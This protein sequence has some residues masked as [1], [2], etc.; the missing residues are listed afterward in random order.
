MKRLALLFVTLFILSVSAVGITAQPPAPQSTSATEV[1]LGTAFTYQGRLTD[2]GAPANGSYDLVFKLYDDSAGGSQVG[3]SV[4]QT[5][6]VTD[7]LFTVQLDFGS[8]VFDGNARWLEI[9]VRPAGSTIAYLPLTPRQELTPAPYALHSAST[10]ALQGHAVGADA[11]AEGQVLTWNGGKWVPWPLPIFFWSLTGNSG[12]NPTTNFL[13][14]TDNQPLVIKTNGAEAIRIDTSGNVGIGTTNPTASLHV[15]PSTAVGQA[16]ADAIVAHQSHGSGSGTSTIRGVYGKAE[17]NSWSGTNNLY[18]VYGDGDATSTGGNPTNN[19]Y[20]VYGKATG[21]I[22]G[23]Q[24]AIGGYFTASGA[25]N[26]YAAIFDQGNVGI[27]TTNPAAR[28]EV[29]GTI[30]STSGGF[31]FPDGTVQTTAAIGGGGWS[32]T[33]NAGTNPAT[34]FLGTTDNQAL[35]LRVN[36]ARAL[37]LEPDAASPNLVGGYNGNNAT[38]GVVGAAIGGG[39]ASGQVNRVTDNYGTVGGGGN[40]QAG[41]ANADPTDATYA[42]VGGGESNTASG[43]HAT[44]GGGSLNIAS[45]GHATIAG[46]REN[47]ASSY[48]ATVGGGWGNVVTATYATIGGGI[49]NTVNWEMATIGGGNGNTASGRSATVAGGESNAASG[50]NATVGGGN[51]N[52]ASGDYA[53]V[54]GG[55]LNTA[56]GSH[57][58]AAGQQAKAN[59]PGCFVWSDTTGIDLPCDNNDRWVARASGGVYFYTSPTSHLISNGVYVAPGGNSWNS[60]SDRATKENFVLVDGRAILEALA[61]LPVHEYNLKSQDPTIRHLGPV[62]QDFYAAFGYGESDRAINM[63]DADGVALAAIQGLYELSQ[64]QAARIQALEAEN[65]ALYQHMDDLE[66]RVT[67]LEQAPSKS[68]APALFTSLPASW[69]LFAG[70]PLFGLVLGWRQHKRGGER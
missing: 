31:R 18:G 60:I 55:R 68:H 28:L 58:F 17:T 38:A 10:G 32:L 35:E 9:G 65:A 57:S 33:G 51:S 22:T 1:A 34:N 69:L 19:V 30:H 40:N 7:G 8:D 54:P 59:S 37:R 16:D 62:A 61:A 64:E 43:E 15:R 46:G 50:Y 41:N 47:I 14:T 4:T 48:M 12:T 70:L 23:T 63:E 52:V 21:T 5:L 6:T 49:N 56:Q 24:T 44:V 27:G 25:D 66:A 53:T 20:G 3:I 2:G 45:Q 42:S 11:P 67:A 29:S 13:G 39:G 36:N 26:N